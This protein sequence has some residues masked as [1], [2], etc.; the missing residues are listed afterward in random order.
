M[1][2]LVLIPNQCGFEKRS[3]S[4]HMGKPTMMHSQPGRTPGTAPTEAV[5]CTIDGGQEAIT[6]IL[7]EKG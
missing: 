1:I 7:A 3:V 5:R 6:E 4:S 2:A